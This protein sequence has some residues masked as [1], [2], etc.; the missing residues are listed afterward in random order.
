MNMASV[1]LRRHR[2]AL[3]VAG[4]QGRRDENATAAWRPEALLTFNDLAIG[5][6]ELAHAYR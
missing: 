1:G 3:A 5:L 4:M 6:P 2:I